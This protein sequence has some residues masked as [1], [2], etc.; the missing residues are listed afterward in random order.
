MRRI[1]S[2]LMKIRYNFKIERY[3]MSYGERCFTFGRF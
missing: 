2:G 3:N 1:F